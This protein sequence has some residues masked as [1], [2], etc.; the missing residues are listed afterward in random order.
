MASKPN[1]GNPE[2]LML[3]AFPLITLSVF[4]LGVILSYVISQIQ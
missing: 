2:K 1:K 3:F 4:A